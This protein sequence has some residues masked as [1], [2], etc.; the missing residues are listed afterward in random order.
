MCNYGQ[1]DNKTLKEKEGEVV[2][3]AAKHLD[4]NIVSNSAKML[5]HST[6]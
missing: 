2:F 5:G 3:P 6:G 4:E 1:L